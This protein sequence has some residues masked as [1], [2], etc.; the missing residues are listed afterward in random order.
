MLAA[1]GGKEHV[2]ISSVSLLSVSCPSVF[3]VFLTHLSSVSS[4]PF[5]GRRHKMIHKVDIS[6]NNDTA[7]LLRRI[8]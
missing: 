4:L 8:K 6:L 7:I 5:S 3:S 2:F 1:G